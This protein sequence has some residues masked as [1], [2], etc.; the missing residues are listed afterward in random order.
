MQMKEENSL[1]YRLF[2]KKRKLSYLLCKFYY[3]SLCSLLKLILCILFL[4]L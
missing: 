3:D 1:C 2:L 4:L